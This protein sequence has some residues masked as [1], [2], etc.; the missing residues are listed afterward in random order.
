MRALN[1]RGWE[2]LGFSADMALAEQDR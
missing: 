2:N 1:E